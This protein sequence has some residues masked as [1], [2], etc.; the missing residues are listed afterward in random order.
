M[1][2]AGEV[3]ATS[4]RGGDGVHAVCHM[5]MIADHDLSTK[6]V[7]LTFRLVEFSTKTRL[8]HERPA[9][10]Y[11]ALIQT[12]AATSGQLSAFAL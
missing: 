6:L 9:S 1:M 7:E 8:I 3:H 2:H 11:A 4:G 12:P 10:L 5:A